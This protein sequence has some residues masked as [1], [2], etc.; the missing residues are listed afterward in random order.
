MVRESISSASNSEGPNS[1]SITTSR[2]RKLTT[3]RSTS[4][5]DF[6]S[7]SDCKL[8][9]PWFKLRE[10]VQD[11]ACSQGE[12][13][14]PPCPGP[15]HRVVNGCGSCPIKTRIIVTMATVALYMAIRATESA[16]VPTE[17]DFVH[18]F[19]V[20]CAKCRETYAVW[21]RG[22][23]LEDDVKQD[24]ARRLSEH[25]EGVCPFHRDSFPLPVAEPD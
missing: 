3:L 13:P 14:G 22:S 12:H 7:A 25:L 6:L 16:H 19:N 2:S 23:E 18:H 17:S 1:W 15:L 9:P 21:G 4:I 11:S 5:L 20:S 8:R 10:N 24:Q